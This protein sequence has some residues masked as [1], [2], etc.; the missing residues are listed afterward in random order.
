MEASSLYCGCLSA[1][2]SGLRRRDS[3]ISLYQVSNRRLRLRCT[4]PL[5]APAP[6]PAPIKRRITRRRRRKIVPKDEVEIAIKESPKNGD[7]LGRRDL[8]KAVVKWI[9]QGMKAM[10]LDIA[11]AEMEEE[12]EFAE[13][14]QRMG[15]G[16]TFV[17]QAQPYLNAVPMPIGIVSMP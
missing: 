6:A 1:S 3:S 13:L 7:P 8:G 10:A 4:T 15:P 14:L 2:I 17:I 9:S 11:T 12:S 5:P 16:L